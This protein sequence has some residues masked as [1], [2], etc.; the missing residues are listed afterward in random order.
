VIF[1]LV[2]IDVTAKQGD[3]VTLRLRG[4]MAGERPVEEFKEALEEHYLDDGVKQ[5]RVDL[6]QVEAMTLDG[7]GVLIMLWK[8]SKARGKPLVIE[9][10]TGQVREK[11]E[12]TGT[13]GPLESETA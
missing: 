4:E 9:G 10:A 13:L 12:L 7:L 11:L 1:P 3:R 5:I 6:S 2:H 8:E